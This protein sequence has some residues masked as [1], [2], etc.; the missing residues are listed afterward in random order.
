MGRREWLFIVAVGVAGCGGNAGAPMERHL[1]TKIPGTVKVV[2]F[3]GDA[4]KDPWFMWELRTKDRQFIRDLVANAKLAPATPGMDRGNPTTITTG[5]WP[6]D[7]LPKIQEMY[8]R[9]P[10]PTDGSIYRV[11]VDAESDRVYVLFVN[12]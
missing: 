3:E 7:R 1:N 9:D 8:F 6:V 12:T 2:N 11:W 10:G 5:W 4:F